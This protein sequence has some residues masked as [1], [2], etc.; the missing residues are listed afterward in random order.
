ML[1]THPSEKSLIFCQFMGEMNEIQSRIISNNIKVFRID[2][3][4]NSATRDSN[5]KEFKECKE[6]CVFIIQIKAGG[7]GLNLQEASRVYITS[8]AWNPATELQAIARSHRTGQ[9]QTVTVRKFVYVGY[10]ELPSI[11]ESMMRVQDVK[12]RVCSEVLNDERLL[13]Q[14]PVNTKKIQIAKFIKDF[15]KV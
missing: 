2:G 10:E 15:F 14:I 7:V 11:E 3:S 8:P 9:T 6:Q 5:M 13:R 4:V 12:S 1:E